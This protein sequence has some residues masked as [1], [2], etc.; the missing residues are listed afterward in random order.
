MSV[1][2]VLE[3]DLR[4]YVTPGDSTPNYPALIRKLSGTQLPGGTVINLRVHNFP[5]FEENLSW[6]RPDFHIQP[7]GP[8]WENNFE[9]A[10][11]LYRIQQAEAA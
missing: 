4:Q 5:V 6:V 8:S 11:A 10:Q 1:R 3:I 9:W 7:T 2:P